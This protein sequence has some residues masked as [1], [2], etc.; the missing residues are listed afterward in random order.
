MSD[1]VATF[2]AVFHAQ[3]KKARLVAALQRAVQGLRTDRD[4]ELI[5][6]QLRSDLD[7]LGTEAVGPEA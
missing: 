6:D 2:F 5:V 7:Q 1:E 3:M 4:V